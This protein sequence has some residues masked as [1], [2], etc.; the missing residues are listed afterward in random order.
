[1]SERQEQPKIEVLWWE[2]CPSTPR[3]LE[4][5]RGIVEELGLDFES[6]VVLRQVESE[7]QAQRE[8]FAGSPTIRIDGR[9]FQ[10]TNAPYRLTCRLY[11]LPDG[12][13]SPLPDR[14]QLRAFVAAAL[15]RNGELDKEVPGQ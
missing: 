15:G 9:E 5:L 2:G 14:D 7:E 6:T 4:M 8:R 12:R 1:M 13:P 3:V 10:P 11:R